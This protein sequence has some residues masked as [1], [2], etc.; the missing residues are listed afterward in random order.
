MALM[1]ALITLV[2]YLPT[3]W[4]DFV[5]YDDDIFFKRSKMEER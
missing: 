5:I 4:F 2:V 1:L 3:G